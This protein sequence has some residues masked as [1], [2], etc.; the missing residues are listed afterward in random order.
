MGGIGIDCGIGE[1]GSS[2]EG[3]LPP[4]DCLVFEWFRS[5]G[6]GRGPECAG[7]RFGDVWPGVA[8][9][10]EDIRLLV[11]GGVEMAREENPGLRFKV[12]D[13]VSALSR[14]STGASGN[15]FIGSGALILR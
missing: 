7:L 14:R 12:F 2:P 9:V 8:F 13:E 10:Y 5:S 4:F 6:S 11:V 15:A 3:L 1:G